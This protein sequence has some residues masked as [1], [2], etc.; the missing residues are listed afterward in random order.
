MSL[1]VRLILTGAVL[2]I[3]CETTEA[4][5]GMAP[6]CVDTLG[7][8]TALLLPRHTLIHI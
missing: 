6:N 3:A 7:K 5:A 4:E 1:N 2:P 8:L